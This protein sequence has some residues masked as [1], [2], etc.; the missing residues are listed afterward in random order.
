M[1]NVFFPKLLVHLVY[2][3]LGQDIHGDEK[4]Y[5]IKNI[6]DFSIIR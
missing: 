2:D 1:S 5:I 3:V 6:A 4:L